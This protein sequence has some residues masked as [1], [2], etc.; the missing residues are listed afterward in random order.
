ML[1][2]YSLW[3]FPRQILPVGQVHVVHRHE[4]KETI[5]EIDNPTKNNA[6]SL[7]MLE[8]MATELSSLQADHEH[9]KNLTIQFNTQECSCSCAGFDLSEFK[10]DEIAQ[11]RDPFPS[12]HPACS[13]VDSLYALSK[14]IHIKM[15]VDKHLI[16]LGI[17]LGLLCNEIVWLNDRT[18]VFLPHLRM[19][20]GFPLLPMHITFQKLGVLPTVAKLLIPNKSISPSDIVTM[21]KQHQESTE[22]QKQTDTAKAK[23]LLMSV[24]KHQPVYLDG[25]PYTIE[26]RASML[27]QLVDLHLAQIDAYTQ[28]PTLEDIP[29][30]T[31]AQL[32]QMR[33]ATVGPMLAQSIATHRDNPKSMNSKEAREIAQQVK[34]EVQAGSK[35]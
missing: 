29:R 22:E 2:R 23:T 4:R 18:K 15:I 24:K 14:K 27:S 28:Y 21:L 12:S 30:T 25:Q 33:L 5:F 16:G 20:V 7:P 9:T 11:H 26:D 35:P 32:E 1:S 19:G 13:V 31:L 6:L 17:I 34:P 10:V 3:R 8:K